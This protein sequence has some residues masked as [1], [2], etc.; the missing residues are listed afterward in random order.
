M[1]ILN[2]IKLVLSGP[3]IAALVN[4]YGYRKIGVIGSFIAAGSCFLTSYTT[5][6]Y[7]CIIAYGIIGGLG[8]GM[9][10]VPSVIVV[11]FYFEKWRPLAT[12]ISVCG[13]G[14]GGIVLPLVLSMILNMNGWQKTFRIMGI[15]TVGCVF[16]TALYRSLEPVRIILVN[17]VEAKEKK[18]VAEEPGDIEDFNDSFVERG[19][20]TKDSLKFSESIPSEM[21]NMSSTIMIFQQYRLPRN[22]SSETILSTNLTTQKDSLRSVKTVKTDISHFSNHAKG[23]DSK[24]STV[25]EEHHHHANFEKYNNK[26]C[27]TCCCCY[28]K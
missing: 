26:F 18:D 4:R 3:F 25:Y 7:V 27:R 21:D 24:L 6:L 15:M 16:C 19:V 28:L 10:Y 20:E 22:V 9:I 1:H 23:T 5:S 14:V 2:K 12:G 17:D 13:A 11:S 8:Y